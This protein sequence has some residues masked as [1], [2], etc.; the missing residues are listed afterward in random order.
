MSYTTLPNSGLRTW[1]YGE[2]GW[3]THLNYDFSRLSSTLLKI[4]GLLDVDLAGLATGDILRWDAG[5]SKWKPKTPLWEAIAET[6]T[7]TTSSTSST[8]SS[9]STTSTVTSTS[10]TSSTS[11]TVTSTS[12]TSST[13]SSS[14]TTTTVPVTEFICDVGPGQA[15]YTTLAAFTAA[16][17]SDLT[18]ATTMVLGGAK[19]G[20]VSDNASVTGSIGGATAT[21]V[22]CS[23][24]QILLESISGPFQ[25]G[26][27][28]RVDESNYF[29]ATDVG[30]S[31]KMVA[32]VATTGNADTAKASTAA[33]TTSSVNKVIIRAA[34]GHEA[35]TQWDTGKYRLEYT[36]VLNGEAALTSSL[37]DLDLIGVQIHAKSNF[38]SCVGMSVNG[39]PAGATLLVDKCLFRGAIVGGTQ[40][41]VGL[42]LASSN[43]TAKVRNTI[44]Y[45]FKN[46]ANTACVGI[47]D[48][49]SVATYVHNATTHNCYFGVYG[50]P[51]STTRVTNT[52]AND[53]VNGFFTDFPATF[54]A[55]SD[56]NCSD[57]AGDAPGANS[58]NGADGTVTFADEGN[59]DFALGA[60]DSNAKD[61]GTS[62]AAHGV[63]PVTEDID[64]TD[65]TSGT[66]DVGAHE[67]V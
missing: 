33:C 62:L 22:H 5:A 24:S 8:T 58:R 14:T 64:G 20:T 51:S 38:M 67:Y 12:S 63:L 17:P 65:R 34:S 57:I 18:A 44:A 48:A 4:A 9:S 35:S 31:A 36:S 21:V 47:W 41:V 55:D 27:Q 56:Y 28:I 7:S 53:C 3:I 61:R 32:E 25:V 52:I 15:D 29:T 11:S 42:Y 16:L 59:D 13:T 26:E 49:D 30:A 39:N 37:R 66:Y 46:G 1:D 19:T 60:G 2:S 40:Y 50:E 10:S 54:H 43:L 23:A 45:D 6:T